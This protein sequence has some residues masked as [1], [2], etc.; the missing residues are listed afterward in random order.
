MT[1]KLSYKVT[2]MSFIVPVYNEEK[3]ISDTLHLLH[4][5][6]L[7]LKISFEI[8]VVN[9]GSKD[10]TLEIIEQI[11]FEL[12]IINHPLNIG[13]GNAIKTGIKSAKFKWIGIVDADG[14]YEINEL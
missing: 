3:S 8:I 13:Y 10:S 14:T 12:K 6:L 4:K 1:S 5:V 7:D 9:D 11:D 2:E